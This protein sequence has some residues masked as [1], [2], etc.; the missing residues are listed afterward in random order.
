[1]RCAAIS[2]GEFKA[3]FHIDEISDT[4]SGLSLRDSPVPLAKNR[5]E[6]IVTNVLVGRN[7][8]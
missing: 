1:M 7:E 8:C 5:L 2:A 4:L 3:M 6:R